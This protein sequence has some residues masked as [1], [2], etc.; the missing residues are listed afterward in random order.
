M[1]IGVIRKTFNIYCKPEVEFCELFWFTTEKTCWGTYQQ[2]FLDQC[3]GGQ[4]QTI[5]LIL[6]KLIVLL[7]H[8]ALWSGT[9]PKQSQF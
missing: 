3:C 6:I 8:D 4:V 7:V 9:I 5:I 2:N 1:L